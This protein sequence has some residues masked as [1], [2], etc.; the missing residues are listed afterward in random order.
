MTVAIGNAICCWLVGIITVFLAVNDVTMVYGIHCKTDSFGYNDNGWTMGIPCN[1]S[2]C[3]VYTCYF[4]T[5]KK[6]Y[7]HFQDCATSQDECGKTPAKCATSRPDYG[8]GNAGPCS[9][10]NS[11]E[12]CNTIDLLKKEQKEK[13]LLGTT[14]SLNAMKKN[15]TEPEKLS[16]N[17]VGTLNT[18]KKMEETNATKAVNPSQEPLTKPTTDAYTPTPSPSTIGNLTKTDDYGDTD[19]PQESDETEQPK[20]EN[21]I[22]VPIE[23]PTTST[24][25]HNEIETDKP[26]STEMTKMPSSKTI[27]KLT[28]TTDDYDDE[29]S[30]STTDKEK[31]SSASS[32]K[33]TKSTRKTTKSTKSVTAHSTETLTN[34]TTASEMPENG[35][36]AESSE[37]T[38]LPPAQSTAAKFLFG[39][40][41]G[42]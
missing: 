22:T 2:H 31:I 29:T 11:A 1:S 30:E 21:S 5:A 37:E 39:F 4:G 24:D 19:E 14:P 8:A 42:P 27:E 10:C 23:N 12:Y 38:A 35:T 34:T 13:V 26:I 33:P 28:T 16:S 40:E 15:A 32:G 9:V 6:A 18:T 41:F 17:P 3:M 25:R 7:A 36:T 20:T